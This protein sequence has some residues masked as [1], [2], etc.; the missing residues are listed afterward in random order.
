MDLA[1][2]QRV[3]SMEG[4]SEDR[5]FM[6]PLAKGSSKRQ[7]T[8][9]AVDKDARFAAVR[10]R[11]DAL[12]AQVN[13]E[14]VRAA[15]VE[16]TLVL[17]AENLEHELEETRARNA[18]LESELKTLREKFEKVRGDNAQL[19]R[20]LGEAGGTEAQLRKK[21]ESLKE[22]EKALEDARS[23]EQE[24]REDQN[25]VRFVVSILAETL[26][27]ASDLPQA[28]DQSTKT[29]FERQEQLIAPLSEEEYEEYSR[30]LHKFT[31]SACVQTLR[32]FVAALHSLKEIPMPTTQTPELE[33]ANTQLSVYKSKAVDIVR[34]CDWVEPFGDA[35]EFP[36]LE[37]L[38]KEIRE[39]CTLIRDTCCPPSPAESE[40]PMSLS[41]LLDLVRVLL[42]TLVD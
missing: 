40:L 24:S 35:G 3:F 29:L 23:G 19:T 32:A 9:D 11:L 42:E 34:F 5:S 15:A 13:D 22:M 28:L 1:K 27:L 20:E 37:N 12:Q 41:A 2:G 6:A 21:L 17:R 7:K 26:E 38:K 33:R 31:K 10:A 30:E 36:P 4:G 16:A 25:R 14:E 18:Q 39:I 8:S